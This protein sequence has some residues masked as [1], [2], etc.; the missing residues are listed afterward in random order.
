MSRDEI[1]QHACW[2]AFGD[3]IRTHR[4]SAAVRE[5]LTLECLKTVC[6]VARLKIG[7]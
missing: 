3:A 7:S 4:S 2:H 5:V 1:N 6:R